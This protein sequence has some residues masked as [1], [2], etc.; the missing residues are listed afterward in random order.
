MSKTIKIDSISL[1]AMTE[2]AGLELRKE[3]NDAMQK[4][5][6]VVLDFQGIELFATPFF[7]ASIGYFVLTL[8]PEKYKEQVEVINLSD[9]GKETYCHSYQNAVSVYE[10]KTDLELIGKITMETI[11]EQ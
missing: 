10:N 4:E 11:E 6:R 3:M 8:S 1:M 5:E 9:L 7:N 2:D